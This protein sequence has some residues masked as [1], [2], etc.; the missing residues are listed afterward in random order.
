[1][2]AP[3]APRRIALPSGLFDVEYVTRRVPVDAASQSFCV[4]GR[5]VATT[6]RGKTRAAVRPARKIERLE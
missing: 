1:M 5:C 4:N 6:P 2:F 3:N